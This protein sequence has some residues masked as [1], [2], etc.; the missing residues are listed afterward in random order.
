MI[1]YEK[2]HIYQLNDRQFTSVT[3]LLHKVEPVKNWKL[4]ARKYAAKHGKTIQ[5]V[6]AAWQL[7]K[8][9]SIVR[10]KG[11]HADRQN[12]LNRVGV[13]QRN[14]VLCTVKFHLATNGGGEEGPILM[15]PDFKLEN[16]TIYTEFMIWD[17]DSLV[18]GTADEVEVINNTINVNDH[19][20]N[21]EIVKE[22]FHVKNVGRN[23]LL[24]PVSHL[25]E[26]N[27][28]TYCLQLSMYMYMLWKKNKHLKIGNLTLNHVQFDRDGKVTGV[29]PHKVP[30]LRN[31][32]KAI[33]EWWNNK[34]K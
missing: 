26:C 1:F 11:Y 4:I 2:D 13:V 18:C 15:Q 28:S 10:G 34:N 6:E 32:V 3:T 16:N 14:N 12:A 22:G 20:T 27:W 25:D 23:K 7:E 19:K 33:L 9:V 21:K 5:E 31:E 29:V 17:E 24:D 8:D 30:Y